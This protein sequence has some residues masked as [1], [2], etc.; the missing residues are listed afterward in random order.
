VNEQIIESARKAGGEFVERYV[1]WLSVLADGQAKL[2]SSAESNQ[3]DWFAAMIT[4]QAEFT[5]Q[6]VK[7][8]AEMSR[9][10]PG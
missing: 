8:F 10:A 6:F 1:S 5:R 4:A 9:H 3:M 2:A 7:A